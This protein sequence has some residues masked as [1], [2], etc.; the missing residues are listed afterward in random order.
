[1]Y[2]CGRI[3]VECGRFNIVFHIPFLHNVSPTLFKT[4]VEYCKMFETGMWKNIVELKYSSTFHLTIDTCEMWKNIFI[5]NVDCETT[6]YKHFRSFWGV[7]ATR[8]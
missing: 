2:E 8:I 3:Y 7:F 5:W 6:I 1:M 4:F